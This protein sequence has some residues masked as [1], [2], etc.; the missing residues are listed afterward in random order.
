[1]IGMRRSDHANHS[2]NAVTYLAGLE[3]PP[4]KSP[5][6]QHVD[7]VN[8]HVNAVKIGQVEEQLLVLGPVGQQLEHGAER[9]GLGP[10][11][12]LQHGMYFRCTHKNNSKYYQKNRDYKK[13]ACTIIKIYSL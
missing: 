9:L 12:V 2:T 11:L 13:Y 3:V 6:D 8:V 7:Q 5:P 1:M 4:E 10:H